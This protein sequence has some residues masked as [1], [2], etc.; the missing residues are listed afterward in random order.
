MRGL[1]RERLAMELGQAYNLFYQIT[2]FAPASFA[3][4]GWQ[5][6]GEALEIMESLGI[7]HVSCTRGRSPFRPLVGGRALKLIE[8]PTTLPSLDEVLGHDGVDQG[9]AAAYL[10][11]LLR[12]GALNVFTMHAEVEGRALAPVFEEFCRRL[13]ADGVRFP[14]LIDA[15]REEAADARG[16]EVVW[17]PIQ[18]RAYEVAWQASALEP[19]S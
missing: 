13:I 5:V 7:T 18:G 16:E 6:T 12:P 11:G 14:R 9:A 17:G 8:L 19:G 10:A 1:E 4:P 15:A 2:G 3:S